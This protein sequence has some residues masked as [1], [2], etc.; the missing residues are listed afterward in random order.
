MANQKAQIH[1]IPLQ[2][3]DLCLNKYNADIKTYEGFRKNNSP[4]YGNVLSPFYTAKTEKVGAKSY[5]SAEGIIYSIKDDGSLYVS[6]LGDSESYKIMELSNSKSLTRETKAGSGNSTYPTILGFVQNSPNPDPYMLCASIEG[7]YAIIDYDGTIVKEYTVAEALEYKPGEK[8]HFCIRTSTDRIVFACGGIL[9]FTNLADDAL[10]TKTL[11]TTAEYDMGEY[12]FTDGSVLICYKN[13][14]SDVSSMVYISAASDVYNNIGAVNATFGI[15]RDP[16]RESGTFTYTDITVTG[17]TFHL[18]TNSTGKVLMYGTDFYAQATYELATNYYIFQY[19]NINSVELIDNVYTLKMTTSSSYLQT[20]DLT[21]ASLSALDTNFDNY[22]ETAVL[23]SLADYN[24]YMPAMYGTISVPDKT[25]DFSIDLGFWS[26]TWTVVL[27]WK[28]VQVKVRDAYVYTVHAKYTTYLL[29]GNRQSTFSNIGVGN[30]PTDPSQTAVYLSGQYSEVGDYFRILYRNNTIS[31][32]SVTSDQSVMGSLL[33]TMTEVDESVPICY[34]K[35]TGKEYLAYKE[36]AGNWIIVYLN[37]DVSKLDLTVVNDR[38]LVIN[39]NEYYNCYDTQEHRPH[40][41]APDYNDRAILSVEYSN[42]VTPRTLD[43]YITNCN[44]WVQATGQGCQYEALNTPFISTQYK[45]SIVRYPKGITKWYINIRGSYTPDDIDIDVYYSQMGADETTTNVTTTPEYQYS[46]DRYT[47]Y[48]NSKLSGSAYENGLIY[49]P[50]MFSTYI[51]GFINQGIVIESDHSYL[52]LYANNTKPIFGITLTS[53]LE[54]VEGAFIIQGQ[55]FVI[56]NNAIYR[57]DASTYATTAI[58]NIA[59]MQLIGYTPYQALFWSDTN[60]TFYTFTGDNTLSVLVQADEIDEIIATAYNPNTM[61][62]Y[63]LT[64][65]AIYIFGTNQLIRLDMP[66]YT[67]CFPINTGAVFVGDDA[68]YLSYNKT[69]GYTAKP[70][71]LETEFYGLGNSVKAVNDCVYIRLFNKDGDTG[72]VILRC[73][74]L[75]EGSI[76]SEEKTFNVTPDMWDK[77]T[78]TLFL[79]YQPKNQAATGFSVHIESPF[80][81]ATL[82]VSESPE[83]VQNSKYNV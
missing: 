42:S 68:M 46:I 78:G 10:V 47:K 12:E 23:G 20:A 72:K 48:I 58:V 16:E 13:T 28:R 59:N 74:T 25:I 29:D 44:Q 27:T 11:S 41:F 81:I 62:T 33:C 60:K 39:T 40:H 15:T 36:T 34:G 43:E 2:T 19:A 7:Q 73:Q 66:G 32:L 67:K 57:Y 50:S 55:Y 18:F 79:R 80:A 63:V 1:T 37:N 71:V 54:G 38:Y 45:R 35:T 31:A 8:V 52:Q 14:A 30:S 64:T 77:D 9:Y 83:T 53:Q 5:V 70:I 51:A 24:L 56:I 65:D 82:Q 21:S 3:T 76:T 61:S 69:T 75:N 4:F 26:K 22:S 6:S 49:V 17:D